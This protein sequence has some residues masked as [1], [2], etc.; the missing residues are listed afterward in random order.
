M[1]LLLA[2]QQIENNILL[3]NAKKGFCRNSDSRY[4]W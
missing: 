2:K 4:K 1:Y 3:W